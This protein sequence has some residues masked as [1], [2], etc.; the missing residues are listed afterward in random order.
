MCE[1][2]VDKLA[3]RWCKLAK[4]CKLVPLGDAEATG[5][6]AMYQC[7]LFELSKVPVPKFL[8][9]KI[10][11]ADKKH[12]V[13]MHINATLFHTKK[14][15]FFGNTWSGDRE[16]VD[17]K[18]MTRTKSPDAKWNGHPAVQCTLTL[19]GKSPYAFIFHSRADLADVKLAV[20]LV[21]T[22]TDIKG[23][24][25]GEEYGICWGVLPMAATKNAADFS[26]KKEDD[27]RNSPLFAGTPRL[28][29]FLGADETVLKKQKNAV[30]AGA[31][32]KFV[33][34][35]QAKADAAVMHLINPNELVGGRDATLAV[36]A[37][38]KDK[39]GAI[40]AGSG[41]LKRAAGCVL[42]LKN[43]SVKVAEGLD[44][45]LI[46]HIQRSTGKSGKMLGLVMELGVHNG[47]KFLGDV[48]EVALEKGGGKGEYSAKK[49]LKL[50]D[51][52]P[53]NMVAVVFLVFASVEVGGE[54]G[55]MCIGWVGVVPT[56]STAAT[57]PLL[58]GNVK[59]HLKTAPPMPC[60]S[61]AV[62]FGD[63]GA[64]KS[65]KSPLLTF[66]VDKGDKE[67]IKTEPFSSKFAAPPRGAAAA[68]GSDEEE[69]EDDLLHAHTPVAHKA[70]KGKGKPAGA[71][72]AEEGAAGAP[73]P[74]AAAA[75]G[76]GVHLSSKK[77]LIVVARK[78]QSLMLMESWMTSTCRAHRRR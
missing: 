6:H 47:R 59:V 5:T 22:V 33:S 38:L 20:E 19:G 65:S 15:A 34:L 27:M 75:G 32:F 51:Y 68:S 62:V 63:D 21:M 1:A 12:K 41:S 74:S 39:A 55:K 8:L 31:A 44:A 3:L 52:L 4:T 28:L 29:L 48:K 26:S 36:I 71:P 57:G 45:R 13:Q 67:A 46:S 9:E 69:D 58:V 64:G 50:P 7:M 70:E 54:K 61:N 30:L 18:C 2:A 60:I 42:V 40:E 14:G 49:D 76:G 35:K 56:E 77:W 53:H 23:E 11:S 24:I 37:G 10:D 73:P 16:T 25:R 78:R 66:D 72:K 43:M 17:D